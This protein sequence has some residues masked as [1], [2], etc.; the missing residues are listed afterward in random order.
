MK[1]TIVFICL[2]TFYSCKFEKKINISIGEKCIYNFTDAVYLKEYKLK[3][4]SCKTLKSK[5]YHKYYS[6]NILVME[7]YSDRYDK[8]GEW[9]FYS[10]KNELITKIKFQDSE[11]VRASKFKNLDTIS[12]TKLHISNKKFRIAKPKKWI[13]IT[14]D[15][16]TI[17][18]N[19]TNAFSPPNI[20][21]SIMSVDINDIIGNVKDVYL[22]TIKSF[23]TSSSGKNMRHKE[24]DII[25]DNKTYE[26]NFEEKTYDLDY[27]ITQTLIDSNDRFYIL[28]TTK[29]KGSLK[30][31]SVIEEIIKNSFKIIKKKE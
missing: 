12:W 2:V 17:T 8:Q 29:R 15:E 26:F 16:N 20:T 6:D 10:S 3:I 24:L 28:T 14:E 23:K 18:F 19:D 30:D 5:A 4:D 27:I 22:K 9:S 31:Y 25:G 21:I 1:K 13:A 11:L 7:G